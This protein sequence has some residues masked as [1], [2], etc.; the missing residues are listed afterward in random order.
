MKDRLEWA[1]AVFPPAMRHSDLDPWF[2]E[3]DGWVDDITTAVHL[4]NADG[5]D[6][7][8]VRHWQSYG[9]NMERV[10][11]RQGLPGVVKWL[12]SGGTNLPP[13]L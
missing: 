10:A 13:M 11:R 9:R 8:A 12:R 3:G 4:R 2:V 7:Q 5:L 1:K 6:E